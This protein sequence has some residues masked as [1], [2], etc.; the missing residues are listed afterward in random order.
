MS[1]SPLDPRK[2]AE[3]NDPNSEYR[4]SIFQVDELLESGFSL[5]GHERNCFFLNTGGRFATASALSGFDFDDDARAVVPVDWDGDGDLDVWVTNRNAPMLRFLQNTSPTG[6]G[7]RWV[8]VR[9]QGTSCNRDAIG[10]RVTVETTA[11]ERHA[12]S[13]KAGEG[14]LSQGSKWLHFGLG[15]A[16]GIASVTVAWPGG[17]PES[18]GGVSPD[19]RW[20]LEQGAGTARPAEARPVPPIAATPMELPGP[21]GSVQARTSSPFPVPQL[22]YIDAEGRDQI[23][24]QGGGGH[25][26]VNLWATW[27]A[28]CRAELT[29]LA[30]RADA[31]A[32]AGVQVLP[33]AVD[34]LAVQPGDNG[35]S[36]DPAAVL[37][38][39]DLPFGGARATTSLMRRIEAVRRRCW[40]I[41]WPLPVPTSFLLDPQGRLVAFYT[42]EVSADRVIADAAAPSAP[43]A[44]QDASL[45]FPGFWIARPGALTAMPV[46][47]AVMGEGDAPAALDYVG[48]AGEGIRSHREFATLMV[49]IGDTL[50]ADGDAGTALAAYEDALAAD[51]EN[52]VVLNNLA[53]QLA[54]HPDE[55]VRDGQRAVRWALKA[56]EISGG[57]DPAILD[58]LAAAQAEVGQF[59][60]AVATAEIAIRIAQAAGNN[61]L[62]QAIAEAMGR[63]RD[64]QTHA[65]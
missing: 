30:A 5:S 50:M 12:R 58:T 53:W 39:W 54:T 6:E 34:G 1:S 42:G 60:D 8:S 41:M 19:G 28:P 43:A 37:Q 49:W 47:L 7:H 27:C 51:P 35:A 31:L 36:A 10:A 45:P 63:Y 15:A 24:G 59:A 17:T 56:N 48:R 65:R 23:V 11:G 20:H 62:V 21:S 29:G 13:L 33:L 55:A 57:S 14:F 44:Y 22:P 32:A 9:L 52:L 2:V 46:A 26:L 3:A 18:F 16:E 25:V 64:G 40:G 38:S 4:K 61:A